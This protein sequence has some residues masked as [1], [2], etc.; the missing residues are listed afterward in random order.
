MRDVVVVDASLALKWVIEEDDSD[1]A[2][3]LLDEWVK[4]GMTLIAPALFIYEVT[5]ILYRKVGRGPLTLIEAQQALERLRH[6]GPTLDFPLDTALSRRAMEVAHQFHLP[7]T[8][9]PHY[10]ALAEREDCPYWT[11]DERL[12]NSVKGTL[13]WVRWLGGYRPGTPAAG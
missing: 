9:D 7:A 8:Y 13:A 12:Y 3:A 1:Q 6:Q 4:S 5:N 11:A 10:L 2:K